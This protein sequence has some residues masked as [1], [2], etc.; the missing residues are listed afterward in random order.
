MSLND[1][2]ERYEEAGLDVIGASPAASRIDFEGNF[3]GQGGIGRSLGRI[4]LDHGYAIT[5]FARN[6]DA[7]PDPSAPL[8]DTTTVWF[9]AITVSTETRTVEVE[10]EVGIVRSARREHVIDPNV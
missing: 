9:D 7:A 2:A 5:S 10:R 6:N 3:E 4:A 8:M 1:L